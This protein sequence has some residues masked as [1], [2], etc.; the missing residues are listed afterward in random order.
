MQS[1]ATM[2]LLVNLQSCIDE[3]IHRVFHAR[4]QTKIGHGNHKLNYDK[5]LSRKK[6]F[7]GSFSKQMHKNYPEIDTNN[8]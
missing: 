5:R 7:D 3:T 6:K 2:M 4:K 1:L 8:S